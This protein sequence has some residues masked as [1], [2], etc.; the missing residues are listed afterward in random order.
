MKKFILSIIAHVIIVQN[1]LADKKTTEVRI[2]K[3]SRWV[4]M[5][6]W[7]SEMILMVP[8]ILILRTRV[9]KKG[10]TTSLSC[11]FTLDLNSD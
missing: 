6:T 9:C 3:N 10:W 1:G 5:P 8:K 2:K 7:K 4:P 11:R